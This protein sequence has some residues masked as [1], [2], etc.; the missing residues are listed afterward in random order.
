MVPP[1]TLDNWL[2]EI[3]KFCPTLIAKTIIYRGTQPER[4]EIADRVIT[5]P[6]GS[7]NIVITTFEMAHKPM[8]NKFLRKLRPDVCVYDEAH[9]L[10]NPKSLKYQGLIK[11]GGKFRLFLTGTPLQNNLME[12]TALLAFIMP[13]LF[14]E[15]QE[16][17]DYIFKHKA[18]TKDANHAALLSAERV[19][20][21]KSMLTPFVLRR[22]KAQV[23]KDL[24]AKTCRVEYC[25]L[26]SEQAELYR[27]IKDRALDRA[28]IIAEGG[29][30]ADKVNDNNNPIM[31]LRKAALHPLLFRRHFTDEMIEE[32]AELLRKHHSNE[33]PPDQERKFLVQE[34]QNMNDFALHQW[35]Q[36]DGKE[37]AIRHF[38]IKEGKVMESGKIDALV[39]LLKKYKANGD[40]VLIFSQFVIMLNILEE[41]LGDD[42]V[43]VP[44]MRIDGSTKVDERQP[45][46][47]KFQ[48]DEDCTAMLLSTGAGGTGINLMMANKVIIF[49]AS[50]NPQEDIQAE[51]RAHRV[52]QTREVEVVRLVSKNTI[53]EQIYRLGQSKLELDNKVVGAEEMNEK[54][55]Q[56]MVAKML[57]EDEAKKD[58]KGEKTELSGTKAENVTKKVPVRARR[59]A[60]A[61]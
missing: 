8:D 9:V 45:I 50:F 32:M 14:A 46:I 43:K 60:K 6:V 47:D 28:C 58:G 57:F 29:K 21:A 12:L 25:D 15:K 52:G 20:R 27:S 22:K 23:M 16:A 3:S 10:K 42:S 36:N 4:A 56:S 18:S 13:D 40:R 59:G 61:T 33:F 37:S 38:D 17:L 5:D 35:C 24:P 34:M 39:E 7:W 26:R 2:A 49:D 41:V 44:F 48:H 1:S 55:G 19:N 31:Q 54:I 53:E 30:V 11:I 51:N